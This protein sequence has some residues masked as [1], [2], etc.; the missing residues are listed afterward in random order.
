MGP[1][2]RDALKGSAMSRDNRER[3][4]AV[5]ARRLPWGGTII[6]VLTIV[7]FVGL[8][9]AGV[10][11]VMKQAGEATKQYGT[12]MVNTQHQSMTLACQMN[13]RSIAQCLQTYAISNES[14]PASQQELVS[15]CG[16]SKVCR[17][18]DPCGVDYVYIPGGGGD[19]PSTTV[20]V[21]EPKPVH[22][23]KCNV[24]FVGGQIASLTPEELK[25]A[26]EATQARRRR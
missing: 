16:S 18:P 20:L 5:R 11:W 13:L 24:L 6:N 3:S 10:I 25:L 15:Y 12:A 2:K 4:I 1:D 26:I 9:A 19:E 23:G 7:I 8:F 14:F 22:D 17:C 21:Y